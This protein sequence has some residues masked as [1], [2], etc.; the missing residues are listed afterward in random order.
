MFFVTYLCPAEKTE[1][2]GGNKN[3]S[4]YGGN[5]IGEICG[6]HFRQL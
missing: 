3:G 1:I 5:N 6:G 2:S 4:T